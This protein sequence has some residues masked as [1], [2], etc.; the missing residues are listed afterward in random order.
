MRIHFSNENNAENH[1]QLAVSSERVSL[2][3]KDGYRS[4]NATVSVPKHG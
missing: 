3:N 4:E 1:G 2:T